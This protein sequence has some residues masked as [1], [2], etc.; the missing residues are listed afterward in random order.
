MKTLH[1]GATHPWSMR[2]MAL[3]QQVVQ[4]HG[5]KGFDVQLLQITGILL[6]TPELSS[7]DIEAP[8][9]SQVTRGDLCTGL[10]LLMTE[11]AHN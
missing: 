4:V 11:T 3:S 8:H 6:L 10:T 5:D 7:E 1:I 9:K 2:P